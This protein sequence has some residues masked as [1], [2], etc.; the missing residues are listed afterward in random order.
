MHA[1]QKQQA[2]QS[3]RGSSQHLWSAKANKHTYYNC[4][5][6]TI[7]AGM[8]TQ[9][10][11]DRKHSVAHKLGLLYSLT[12]FDVAGGLS[13]DDSGMASAAHVMDD[14]AA[15]NGGSG[16]AKSHGGGGEPQ[17]GSPRQLADTTNLQQRVVAPGTQPT[18]QTKLVSAAS[19]GETL[20]IVKNIPPFD[21]LQ[22]TTASSVS[23]AAPSAC[24][25]KST[26]M[27]LRWSM[28][29][30]PEYSLLGQYLSWQS[31]QQRSFQHIIRLAAGMSGHTCIHSLWTP[32]WTPMTLNAPSD[33]SDRR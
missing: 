14:S 20:L 27:L 29:L 5:V 9:V 8:T 21:R 25:D 19:S 26:K 4:I 32:C 15:L 16:S 13:E 28:C 11:P 31:K 7:P 1:L 23:T 12:T 18:G 24:I 3:H 10:L 17:V 22:S 2:I 30:S 6:W 33:G